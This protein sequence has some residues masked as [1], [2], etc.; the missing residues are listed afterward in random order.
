MPRKIPK[1]VPPLVSKR[2]GPEPPPPK[3][4]KTDV[5]IFEADIQGCS[6]ALGM[7]M[8]GSYQILHGCAVKGSQRENSPFAPDRQAH[9][10]G[11]RRPREAMRA[12]SLGIVRLVL[13]LVL[14]LSFG[15]FGWSQKE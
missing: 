11:Q 4:K 7:N 13:F 9:P 8:H 3:P 6:Q 2:L 10:Q 12:V 5:Q 14:S 15:C 1:R